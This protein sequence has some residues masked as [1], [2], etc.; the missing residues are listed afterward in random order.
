M[1]SIPNGVDSHKS[2]VG[3]SII[4]QSM[5]TRGG[6][7]NI[8]YEEE[9][10]NDSGK[11][12][13][14]DSVN[15]KSEDDVSKRER[16]ANPTEF[17]MSCIEYFL[18]PDWEKIKGPKIWFEAVNQCFFSLATSFGP[19][20]MFGS[21]NEFKH[22]TYRD[23]WIVSCLD[24]FTSLFAGVI[25]FA[26]LGNLAGELGVEVKDVTRG[27]A[28]LSFVSFA[29]ALGTFTFLP[30]VFSILFYL[31][32]LTLGIGSGVATTQAI[33]SVVCDEFPHW[34]R[35]K[36]V[37]TV[38]S[39]GFLTGIMYVTPG[40]MFLLDLVSHF[41][42][43]YVIYL[44]ALL[45]VFAIAWLYGV[46]NIMKDLEFM[47]GMKLGWYWRICWA[48]TIPVGLTSI[49]AYSL[50]TEK[51]WTL[52]GLEY[53]DFAIN[54]GW[55]VSAIGIGMI[56]AWGLYTIITSNGSTFIEKLQNSF[57]PTKSWGP[58]DPKTRQEWLAFKATK[59]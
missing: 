55:V 27:D 30:Q 37:S 7:V 58:M 28:G 29:Q 9:A 4:L 44:M 33:V 25:V 6:L 39:L 35:W 3:E 57:Q 43:D 18:T 5:D 15:A 2:F 22:N 19:L 45:E 13:A 56:P 52:N 49:L 21:F 48:F 23:A 11:D 40:G 46:N 12:S 41:G 34:K 8:S 1:G 54:S 51:R 32:L 53:P 31:M 47:L 24:T 10:Q 50:A 14:N 20:V 16:W 26:V 59:N 17:L 42:V 36:V 38:C